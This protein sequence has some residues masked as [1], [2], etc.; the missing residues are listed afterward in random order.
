MALYL[1]K[2]IEEPYLIC[3]KIIAF[4]F[5][6]LT[7]KKLPLKSVLYDWI[8]LIIAQMGTMATDTNAI[9]QPRTCAQRGST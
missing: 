4:K 5:I 6:Q 2:C 8:I 9:S 1:R 7:C 3:L